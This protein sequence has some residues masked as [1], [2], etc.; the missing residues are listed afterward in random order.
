MTFTLVVFVFRIVPRYLSG[1]GVGL[2]EIWYQLS[3]MVFSAA[4]LFPIVMFC[5]VRFSNRFAGPMVRV[6][7]SLKQLARGEAVDRLKFRNGDFWLDI[8]NEINR[9]SDKMAEL[10][11]DP[12]SSGD[13]QESDELVEEPHCV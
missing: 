12:E 3:P 4:A 7:R 13:A 2:D 5:A 9:V 10:S 11:A 6:R 1:E 8:A